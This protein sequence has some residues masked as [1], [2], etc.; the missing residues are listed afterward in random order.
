M[1]E[2]EIRLNEGHVMCR[3]ELFM[4]RREYL[5][6][7]SETDQWLEDDRRSIDLD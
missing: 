4:V 1:T 7:Q 5:A 6:K 3:V 2:K